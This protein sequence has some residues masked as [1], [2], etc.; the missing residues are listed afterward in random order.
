MGAYNGIPEY[1][2]HGFF[3][4]FCDIESSVSICDSTWEKGP[5]P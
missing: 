5:I 2:K 3:V 4:A 1:S